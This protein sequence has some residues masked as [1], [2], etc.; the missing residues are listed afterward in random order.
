MLA[1]HICAPYSVFSYRYYRQDLKKKISKGKEDMYPSGKAPEK[2]DI[3]CIVQVHVV[4]KQRK[5]VVL[6]R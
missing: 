6:T 3:K 4:R 2:E 1:S 5:M